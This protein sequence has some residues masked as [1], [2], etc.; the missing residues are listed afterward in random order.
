MPLKDSSSLWESLLASCKNHGN[1]ELSKVAATHLF[2]IEPQNAGNH[3]LLS[4]IYVVN[5]WWEEVARSKKFLKDGGVK[6]VMGK[7]WIEVKGKF[8]MDNPYGPYLSRLRTLFHWLE[9]G[10][11][12]KA[13]ILGAVPK[14]EEYEPHPSESLSPL[15]KKLRAWVI[16]GWSLGETPFYG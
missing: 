4:N 7:S 10:A 5:K 14:R 1:Y 2:E 11:Y 9:I 3:V 6:K 15:R 12:F 16:P 13:K 8:I